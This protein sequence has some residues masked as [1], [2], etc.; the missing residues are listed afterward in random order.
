MS[1]PSQSA[2]VVPERPKEIK[3]PDGQLLDLADV[4]QVARAY[5]DVQRYKAM[6]REAETQLKDALI[7][8]ATDR[9]EKTFTLHEAK[10]EIKGGE[11]RR[12]DAQGLKRA[13]KEAGM[14]EE[15]IKEIVVE[16][17]EYKVSAVE[18]KRAARA[19]EKYAEIVEANTTVAKKTPSVSVTRIGGSAVPRSP[20]GRPAEK[21]EMTASELSAPADDSQ[22]TEK[23]PA[24][25]EMPW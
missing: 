22:S 20:Q 5:D 11:E 3:L 23:A 4:D 18:A 12:Y 1:K 14:P 24:E 17:I 21:E 2:P 8:H 19:N 13:L 7:Q 9:G 25:E 10:V 6:L 16:T 15:R